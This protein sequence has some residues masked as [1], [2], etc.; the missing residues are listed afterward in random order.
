MKV[1]R[2]PG[3][4]PP[5]GDDPVA[6][7]R[8]RERGGHAGAVQAVLA[9]LDP[10]LERLVVDGGVGAVVGAARDVEVVVE[11]IL[12]AV[13]HVAACG[14]GAHDVVG[15]AAPQPQQEDDQTTGSDGHR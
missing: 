8:A 3:P 2:V 11:A 5:S 12:V 9:G 13:A 10:V 7:R 15:A 14:C 1:L 4:R 6:L